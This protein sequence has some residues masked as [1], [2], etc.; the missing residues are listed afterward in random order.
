M[1]NTKQTKGER[2]QIRVTP[3]LKQKLTEVS[4]RQGLSIS[5]LVLSYVAKGLEQDSITEEAVKRLTKNLTDNL[6]K[7][8]NLRNVV[9]ALQTKLFCD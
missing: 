6:S 3:K 9:E 5:T 8:E 2:L 4:E 1:N 7:P